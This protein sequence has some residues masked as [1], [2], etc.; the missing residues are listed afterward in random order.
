V[1]EAEVGMS[2]DVEV[3]VLT[4]EAFKQLQV[5]LFMADRRFGLPHNES[6]ASQPGV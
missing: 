5:L 1:V 3:V 6:D 2:L 4:V